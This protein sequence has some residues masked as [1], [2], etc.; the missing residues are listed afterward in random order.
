MFDL[1]PRP[2]T[3]RPHCQFEWRHVAQSFYTSP[4]VE[5]VQLSDTCRNDPIFVAKTFY[6]SPDTG[7]KSNVASTCRRRHSTCI[8][9]PA[10]CRILHV[11]RLH[12]SGVDGPLDVVETEGLT[13]G[14]P[15]CA[16]FHA[17]T[18]ILAAILNSG[19]VT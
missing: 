3:R 18:A 7:D 2:S 8:Q 17:P 1:S 6:M 13:V 10:T 16:L 15:T 12:V 9:I 19:S 14:I 4:K 11:E 5:H